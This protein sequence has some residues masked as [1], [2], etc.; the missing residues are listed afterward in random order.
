MVKLPYEF[1]EPGVPGVSEPNLPTPQGRLAGK[2]LARLVR[3]ALI[4]MAV[5]HP[6]APGPCA[7]CAFVEGTIPNGCPETVLDAFKCAVEGVPF[8]CHKGMLPDG[9]PRRICAGWAAA[10][11]AVHLHAYR[12]KHK[13]GAA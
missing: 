9:T 4:D 2:E 8:G 12:K 10:V 1:S 5:L 7:E 11:D 13:G 3:P 6:D